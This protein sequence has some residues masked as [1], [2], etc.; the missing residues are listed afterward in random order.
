MLYKVLISYKV[1]IAGHFPCITVTW[2]G[3][4]IQLQKA[5]KMLDSGAARATRFLWRYPTARL[6]LLFYL[7]FVHLFL[8]YL[9]H[10]LQEQADIFSDREVAESM[11]LANHTLP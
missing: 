6:I 5:A 7:V 10:R 11:G 3:A 2:L 9:L 8:M 4:S 1:I